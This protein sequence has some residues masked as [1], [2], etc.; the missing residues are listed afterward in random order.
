VPAVTNDV[1]HAPLVHVAVMHS[2]AGAGQSAAV[3]QCVPPPVPPVPLEL[4]APPVPLELVAPPMPPVPLEL[5]LVAPPMPPVP[6]EL[7]LV[8][9]PMPPVPLELVVELV[10]PPVPLELL[11]VVVAAPPLPPVSPCGILSRSTFAISSQPDAL[12]IA[13][14]AKARID[15]FLKLIGDP[16]EAAGDWRAATLPPHGRRSQE[17]R[18][19]AFRGDTSP[20][21]SER[22]AALRPSG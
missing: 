7:E 3:V 5:E 18:Q 12:M 6:L 8:A 9:P 21:C 4:V 10:E 13:T 14:A 11:L 1:P 16:R 17:T 2:F 15:C 20:T 19:S 22:V